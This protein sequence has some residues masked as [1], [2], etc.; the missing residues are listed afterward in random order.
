MFP[1]LTRTTRALTL[2]TMLGASALCTTAV[3]SFAHIPEGGYADLVEQVAPAVVFI[4]VTGKARADNQPSPFPPGSPFD[5]FFN[6]RAPDK[7]PQNPTMHGL[8]SGYII[9]ATGEIVTNHH[10]VEGASAVTVKLADGRKFSAE[11]VGSDKATDIALLKIA[12]VADLPTVPFGDSEGLRV[13]EAVVAVGNPFGLGGTVTVGVVS[14]LGRDI[15]SGPYDSY[16]QTDAAINRGNSGG[17]LFNEDGQVIGMNT[18][19]FSPSGGSVG[20]GFS[21]P[22]K[23]VQQVVAQLRDGGEVQR[24]WLGVQ[25]QSITP[26]IAA[27]LGLERAHGALVSAVQPDSPAK[28]AGIRQGDVIVSVGA[29]VIED[30]RALPKVIASIAAGEG[31][32][33]TVLR[34]GSEKVLNVT[35]GLLEPEKLTRASAPAD[36]PLSGDP[37][38]VRVDRLTPDI[39]RQLGLSGAATGVLVVEVD[40]NGANAAK[41]RAGDVIEEAGGQKI[42]SLGDLS[43]ALASVQDANSVLL[44]I[45]RGGNPLY[46]GAELHQS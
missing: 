42:A 37:L 38:G 21:I 11:V 23:T 45:N 34:N 8:G 19:I 46:V 2:A 24:G 13:G 30:M 3:P 40:P 14:A 4:E 25:I 36:V 20:I 6:R 9:S 33:I 18:A 22:S 27:A 28:A 35:I 17:P 41:L 12:D 7:E 26:D 29:Q 44:R 39:A 31:A 16:I 32:S 5:E 15:N 1:T 43:A 10:V